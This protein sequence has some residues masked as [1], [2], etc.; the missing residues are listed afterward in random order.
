[1]AE[2]LIPT[3]RLTG[4]SHMSFAGYP[5]GMYYPI[6]GDLYLTALRYLSFGVPSW[7]TLYSFAL[8]GVLMLIPLAVYLLARAAAGPAAGI[9]AGALAI[10]DVGGWRQG[11]SVF[12]I[13]WGVWPYMLAVCLSVVAI[14]LLEPALSHPFA[15]RPLASIGLAWALAFSVMTH[16]MSAVFLAVAAP[17]FVVAFAIARF[18]EHGLGPIIARAAIAGLLSILF[19]LFWLMPQLVGGAE[20]TE[21]FGAKWLSFDR[22]IEA[23]HGNTLFDKFSQLA[24]G[25]GLAGCVLSFFSRRLWPTFLAAL[26]VV[27]LLFTVLGGELLAE[28]VQIERLAAFIKAIWFVLAGLAVDRMGA[29]GKFLVLRVTKRERREKMESMFGVCGQL[30]A[31]GIAAAIVIVDW[32]DHFDKVHRFKPLEGRRWESVVA[33]DRWLAS[34]QTGRFDR[35]LYQPG[36]VCTK[37]N[38]RSRSCR[39]SYDNHIFAAGPLRTGLPK[40]K[41][42]F[43]PAVVFRHLP[44][45][46]HWPEDTAIIKRLQAD[47]AAL[48]NLRIRWIVSLST[49]P[50]G[51]GIDEVKRFGQV[52]IYSVGGYGDTPVQIEGGGEVLTDHFADEEIQVRVSGANPNS[53]LHFPIAFHPYWEA[54]RNGE[55]LTIETRYIVSNVRKILITVPA[56]DGETSLRFIRPWYVRAAQILSSLT[57]V[58]CLLWLTLARRLVRSG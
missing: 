19:A 16:P 53:K 10:G 33:A 32:D 2:Q 44:I 51:P 45:T 1:M 39:Y 47:P 56:L 55:P 42:G 21:S 8:L 30:A 57:F 23:V 13:Y 34:K 6:G 46:N 54:H 48:A 41:F 4:W 17:G 49:W 18:R 43:E 3:G 35:V 26:V 20:L 24:W 50:T 14:R 5:A 15:K 40:V 37:G 25:I 22:L 58:F 28:K 27:S 9:I 38:I 31:L 11:G 29:L 36:R 52:R 12:T 7:E